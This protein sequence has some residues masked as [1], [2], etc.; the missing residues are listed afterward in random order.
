MDRFSLARKFLAIGAQI[1]V[2]SIDGAR[3]QAALQIDVNPDRHG[4]RFVLSLNPERID[5]VE[6]LD[7]KPNDRHLLLMVRT[8][9]VGDGPRV[10]KQRFLC[11][12]DERAWFV[13][14]VPETAPASSVQEAM[15]ALKPR[16]VREAQTARRVKPKNRQR[17]RNAG[18]V[19]QGEWFFV[20][21]PNLRVDPW[22]VLR[23]EPLSRGRGKAHWAEEAVRLGGETVY[24]SRIAP[25]GFTQDE[26]EAWHMANEGRQRVLWHPM[27]RNARVYVRGRIRHPDHKTIVLDQWH[28]VFMNTENQ[29]Q[30]M[31]HVAFLD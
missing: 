18:F 6:V 28:E 15:E 23:N 8:K 3:S 10:S 30:A 9:R 20:S 2:E 24:V 11:G 1:R 21:R 12:H 25:N 16:E 29:S 27:R 22:I 31:Q 26:Y 5:G 14:A 17:R 13:A 7:V 4:G 19:R